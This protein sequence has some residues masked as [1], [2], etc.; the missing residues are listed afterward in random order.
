M[1]KQINIFNASVKIMLNTSKNLE[2][3]KKN[4]TFAVGKQKKPGLRHPR[5]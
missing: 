1:Y 4:C 2:I 5:R 3:W